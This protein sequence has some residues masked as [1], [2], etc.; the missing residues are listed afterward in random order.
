[1][2]RFYSLFLFNRQLRI[3][4]GCKLTYNQHCVSLKT[5]KNKNYNR[6]FN[7]C[8]NSVNFAINRNNHNQPNL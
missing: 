6:Q 2:T 8:S 5:I 4:Y 1:M 7:T 3:C